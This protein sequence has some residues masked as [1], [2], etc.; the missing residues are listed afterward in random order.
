MI[1]VHVRSFP[2]RGCTV[3]DT[4]GNNE[5]VTFPIAFLGDHAHPTIALLVRFVAGA[6]EV[7]AKVHALAPEHGELEDGP[8]RRI[9]HRLHHALLHQGKWRPRPSDGATSWSSRCQCE[10]SDVQRQGHLLDALAEHQPEDAPRAQALAMHGLRALGG[11]G[12]HRPLHG[13]G[14][15]RTEQ[16]RAA[17]G[18]RLGDA[19]VGRR[20]FALDVLR[21]GPDARGLRVTSATGRPGRETQ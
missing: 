1:R 18:D 6:S 3:I 2:A 10:A 4:S 8:L 17:L 5:M 14:G 19:R 21:E 16:T 15:Q 11:E 9:L 7:I 20:R 13:A 12:G